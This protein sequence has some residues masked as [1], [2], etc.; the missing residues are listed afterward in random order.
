MVGFSPLL[1]SSASPLALLDNNYALAEY[2]VKCQEQ[3]V[4]DFASKELMDGQNGWLHEELFAKKNRLAKQ[5]KAAIALMHAE[6]QGDCFK[7]AKAAYDNTWKAIL[8]GQKQAEKETSDAQK[9]IE[10]EA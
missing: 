9:A 10:H 7:A 3:M 6:F 8:D 2:A 5:R 4:A 1:P